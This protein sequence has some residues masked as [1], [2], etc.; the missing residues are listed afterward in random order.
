MRKDKQM[1]KNIFFGHVKSFIDGMTKIIWIL[2][3]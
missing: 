2:D 1:T 3:N